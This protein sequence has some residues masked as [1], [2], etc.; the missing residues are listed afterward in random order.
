[1]PPHRFTV[2]P[3]S[4]ARTAPLSTHPHCALILPLPCLPTALQ[5]SPP[6]SPMRQPAAALAYRSLL[7]HAHDPIPPSPLAPSQ[8][9][10]SP[11]GLP[12]TSW[13]RSGGGV[14]C[15]GCGVVAQ[16]IRQREIWLHPRDGEIRWQRIRGDED[17]GDS[18]TSRFVRCSTGARIHGNG[19]ACGS[20]YPPPLSLSWW[21]RMWRQIQVS[22]S[23][24]RGGCGGAIVVHVVVSADVVR[25][26][27]AVVSSTD[28]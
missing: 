18:G 27:R 8:P 4:H 20:K 16:G 7:P 28:D 9:F 5:H 13:A 26:W 3:H 14:R 24:S 17:G 11:F 19:D 25:R 6:S 22:P 12:L 23:L 15:G 21:W 10:I 1:M 2:P